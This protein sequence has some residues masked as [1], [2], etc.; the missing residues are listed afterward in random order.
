MGSIVEIPSLGRQESGG[1]LTR[2]Q[3]INQDSGDTEYYTPPEIVEAA[4]AVMGGIDLDP[5]S[6]PAANE[7][8]RA[9]RIYTAADDGLSLPWWGR[10]WMNHPFSRENNKVWPRK[11]IAEYRADNVDQARCITFAA[12]SEEWFRPLYDFPMCFLSPRTNYMLPDGTIKPG[13]TKGSV[14]TYFGPRVATFAG[15]F[16]ALGR[17]MIPTLILAD[18]GNPSGLRSLQL[19]IFGGGYEQI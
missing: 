4:R 13:V 11:L 17:V 3:L 10:V 8:V 12:T 14:V 9:A 2:A 16:S 1:R 6:S 7:R 5:A 18:Y 19:S 15:V